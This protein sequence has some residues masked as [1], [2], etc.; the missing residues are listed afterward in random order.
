MRGNLFRTQ[1]LLN[2]KFRSGVSVARAGSRIPWRAV[3]VLLHSAVSCRVGINMKIVLSS[4]C[5]MFLLAAC[6]KAPT[7]Q[8]HRGQG[9]LTREEVSAILGSSVTS[10]EGAATD[11]EY[12]TDTLG[13]ETT[14]GIEAAGDSE[15]AMAGARKA[16]AMLGGAPEDVPRL[17]DDAFFGAMSVLYVRR[18]DNVITITPPN[19]QQIASMAAYGKVTDAKL[20]SAEQA[21]AM[22]DFLQTEKKDPLQAGLKSGDD[23]QGALA[24]VAA[25]SKKQGTPYETQ[26]RTVAVALASKVLTKL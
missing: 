8:G 4:L 5:L 6:A 20:G 25:A 2:E 13:L 22:Q 12:K 17:G 18:G 9:V 7:P 11:M 16:T 3:M 21:Q 19:F 24:T 23:M 15:Q 1:E 10:V 14:I 26:G